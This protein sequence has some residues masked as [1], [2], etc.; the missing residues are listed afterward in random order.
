MNLNFCKGVSILGISLTIASAVIASF[1]NS[2][3]QEEKFILG[4]LTNDSGPGQAAPS[5]ITCAP[6]TFEGVVQSACNASTHD[7]NG[8][9]TTTVNIAGP[10]STS[11]TF[12][13][14]DNTTFAG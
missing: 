1:S 13:V 3:N 8:T 11:L 12:G 4:S 10:D 6:D 14:D 9:E 2:K 5:S 7:P